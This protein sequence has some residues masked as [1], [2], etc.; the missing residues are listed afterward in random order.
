M[1]R[2]IDLK[3]PYWYVVSDENIEEFLQRGEKEHG[4]VVF[5]AMSVPDYE[6]MS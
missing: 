4:H 6:I 3:E 1:P 2:E 5:F